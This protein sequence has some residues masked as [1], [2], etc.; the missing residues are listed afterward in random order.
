[1]KKVGRVFILILFLCYFAATIVK[2]DF[3]GNLLSPSITLIAFI[4]VYKAFYLNENRKNIRFMGLLLSLG[5]LSWVAADV[6]FAFYDMVLDINPEEVTVITYCY[7]LTNLLMAI[8]LSLYGYYVLRKW[9]SVQVL[10]DSI[11]ISFFVI[12]L[13]WI[14]FLD[15]NVKNIVLLR[16]DWISS[17]C[18]LLDI[19]MIIWIA[20]WF[21]SIRAGKLPWLL[22]FIS[23]GVLLFSMTDLVYYYQCFFGA[24]DPNTI[25]DA[26]YVTAFL[27]IAIAAMIQLDIRA[28]D[29]HTELH[30]TGR[31]GK[32]YALVLAPVLLIIFKGFEVTNLLQ[33]ITVILIYNML[34][35]YIQSNIYKE[36]LFRKEHEINNE[37]E[38]K[39][40]VRT[41]ELEEKNRVL[42]HLLDQ[43]FVTG[44]KNR[45]YLLSSLEKMIASLKDGETIVL[46]Y[47][48]INRF[49]MITT[50]YGH[51]VGD[52]ILYEMAEKLKPLEKM[53]KRTILTS[54]GDDT[55]VFA[56]VGHS[57]Y[58]HGYEFAKE[59]IRLG[60]D[61]YKIDDYQIRVTVNIGISMFPNDSSTKEELIKH[62]DIAMSQARHQG[63]NFAKEFDMNLSSEI[64]RRNTIEILL[65]KVNFN[66]EFK[67]Y[68]QPQ[69]LTESKKLIGFEALLRWKTPSGEMIG[70]SEF[71]PVAE[72]TGYILPIGDWVMMS[73]MK[74][75]IEWNQLFHNKIMIGINVS[76]KQLNSPQFI[77]HLREEMDSLKVDPEWVDLEITESLQLQENPDVLNVLEN[78]KNLGVK[79]SIDDFGTGYSS[80][81]YLKNFPVDRI[82]LA[83]EL[84]DY[85][86]MDEFDYELVKAIILLSK[87]RDIRVIAE[88]VE[89]REQ[90]EVLKEL[91]CDE[92]QGYYFG[93]PM[94][95]E[96]I[97]AT[98]GG[99]KLVSTKYNNL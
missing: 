58:K 73:V 34:S 93:R 98:Y 16:S 80:L 31:K 36:G 4:A 28:S 88:G 49:K 71:I 75:L 78:I 65:K 48:D 39:V 17:L 92:V 37:L 26:I 77:N 35:T 24:Y 62:A 32:S 95:V 61:I 57:D 55:F 90:W 10:L 3:L 9:N 41:E 30:N 19:L 70:P 1:M 87:A 53:A 29:L 43:D 45:R 40:K 50:M 38:Q 83:K 85:I 47:I 15:E 33:F 69:L 59:A 7:S 12:E 42:Q 63:F 27:L 21:M 96:V 91:Q 51:Y 72:E 60:S 89:T 81:S 18:I 8:S 23:A 82:K 5:I 97:E 66:Q 56:T 20:I 67:V 22:R 46:L 84:I 79:I 74:Q 14:V 76:L 68:Y 94:P 13:V 11:I 54:Y 64:F 25:I 6:L 52:M 99:T 44:L 86:H 2:S